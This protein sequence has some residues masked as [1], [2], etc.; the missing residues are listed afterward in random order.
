M[1][2]SF[3]AKDWVKFASKKMA[4]YSLWTLIFQATWM[5]LQIHS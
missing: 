4:V 1:Q 2:I 3:V 5:I